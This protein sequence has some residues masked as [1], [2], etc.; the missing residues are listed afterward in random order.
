M[1]FSR[2]M[3]FFAKKL[4]TNVPKR[5]ILLCIDAKPKRKKS[6]RANVLSREPQAVKLRQVRL[7]E[8][9]FEGE[10]K[11]ETRVGFDGSAPVT[12][13]DTYDGT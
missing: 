8:W 11:S 9:A 7:C 4:L 10:P 2:K 5:G 1:F 3:I 6:S 12:V 13:G